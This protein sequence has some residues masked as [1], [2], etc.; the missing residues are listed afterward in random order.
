MEDFSGGRGG[1]AAPLGARARALLR[2][3]G[4]GGGGGAGEGM[5]A[6]AG[7]LLAALAGSAADEVWHKC[8]TFR[9][10][11]E[12]VW[13]VLWGWGCPEAVCRLGLFHSAYG[14]SFVAMRLFDP[15][16][17]RARLRALIGSEA[18]DLVFLFC[19]IDRQQLEAAVLAEG[20]LRPEGYRLRNVQAAATGGEAELFVSCRQARDLI[21]ETLGDYAEQSFGWQS[22]LEGG[23]PVA[24]ALWPGPMRPTLRLGRL[25]RFAA[26]VRDSVRDSATAE[27]EDEYPLPPIFRD[28]AGRPCGQLLQEEDELR[29][30]D[31]YWAVIAADTPPSDSV[32]LLLEASR[33]NPHVGEP[34]IVRAQLLV[35]EGCGSGNPKLLEEAAQA[36]RRG[37]GLLEDWGTA[38]DK[39]MPWA[40]WVNWARV[41]HLQAFEREWPTTHGGVESLGAV[42]PSQKF[43]KLNTSRSHGK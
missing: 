2:G 27:G 5:D 25:S 12:G 43:R 7:G 3:G 9:E 4:G 23:A 19:C 40:A 34:H 35:A 31:L 21:V 42:L 11:L 39:R 1:A 8:G 37:L 14:N 13:R 33:L 24:Q 6:R 10:H 17:D 36:A 15:A 29:A 18:E 28:A 20:G 30:R 16:R 38:W 22:D 41:L 26:A 32:A